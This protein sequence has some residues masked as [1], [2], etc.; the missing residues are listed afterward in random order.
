MKK[1]DGH[2]IVYSLLERIERPL[3]DICNYFFDIEDANLRI[4]KYRPKYSHPAR[5]H[6]LSCTIGKQTRL[7]QRQ[8]SKVISS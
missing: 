2:S 5:R 6:A 1:R 7:V 8:A 3:M 4:R